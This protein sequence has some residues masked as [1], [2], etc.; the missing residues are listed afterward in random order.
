MGLDDSEDN[1]EAKDDKEDV[2][3]E[4]FRKFKNFRNMHN[5]AQTGGTLTASF[6]GEG[7]KRVDNWMQQLNLEYKQL[8]KEKKKELKSY[9]QNYAKQMA[10][11]KAIMQKELQENGAAPNGPGKVN[12]WFKNK[13]DHH[14]KEYESAQTELEGFTALKGILRSIKLAENALKANVDE[15][16]IKKSEEKE[17]DQELVLL[18]EAI[19]N[20][21]IYLRDERNVNKLALEERFQELLAIANR[22]RTTPLTIN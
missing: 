4:I 22:N 15:E 19:R 13:F 7:L 1:L 2:K 10:D 3:T 18:K 14:K 16:K 17:D 21:K 12:A 6:L 8:P 11:F 5:S 20:G 9:Y